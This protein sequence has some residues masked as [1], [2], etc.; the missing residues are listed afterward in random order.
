[1]TQPDVWLPV[2]LANT[3]KTSGRE[4]Y[5][6][7]V[8]YLSLRDFSWLTV[9]GRLKTD[10][11]LKQA[12]AELDNIARLSDDNATVTAHSER[13][14]KVTVAPAT[15]LNLPEARDQIIP[16]GIAATLILTLVLAVVCVNISNML[17]ARA[18]AR[19]KEIGV[20]LA[21]GASRRRIIQQLI[22][23]S[24]LLAIIGAIC[25][26]V[27]ASFFSSV[28]LSILPIEHVY[29][30]TTINWVVFAYCLLAATLA[31][32]LFGVAP[33]I[34]ATR[35][36][37][38][39]IINAQVARVPT[40]RLR[41]SLV[42]AQVALSMVLLT[43]A[44]LLLRGMQRAQSTQLNWQP[45][46][47][48]A[49]SFDLASAGYDNTREAVFFDQLTAQLKGRP[50]IESVGITRSVPFASSNQTI[51]RLDE[52]QEIEARYN[53]VTA[54][55]FKTLRIPI[56]QGRQFTNEEAKAKLPYAVISQA[57]ARRL[58]PAINPIGQHFNSIYEV[59]G[60]TSD[61]SSTTVGK[62]DGPTFYLPAFAGEQVG[63]SLLV[64][65]TQG[66]PEFTQNLK[67][68]VRSLDGNVAVH[69]NSLEEY[70]QRK[71]QPSR[72]A[73]IL[74]SS[75][76][77]LAT[78]MAGLG[79]Y[80]L[81]AFLVSQRIREIGIRMALGAQT[82][83]ILSLVLKQGMKLV[84]IGTGLGLAT[85]LIVSRLLAGLIFGVSNTDA[86]T[87][88]TVP[89]ILGVTAFAACF[90]PARRAARVNPVEALRYE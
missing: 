2:S 42:V 49:V 65:T 37:V 47:V 33:A 48:Y 71:L 85:S 70:L 3:L 34:Q 87:F 81:V 21:L 57:M 24:L 62:L 80:G 90:L 28:S 56:M 5:D 11:S 52:K 38:V 6:T 14:T 84:V 27:L 39:L 41:S 9:I 79:L 82:S 66:R 69:V 78:A 10:A 18:I 63:H 43:C 26:L 54:D 64:R 60:V 22:I 13:H 83:N 44:G 86:L 88:T 25:G 74:S 40:S 51:V 1:V 53:A 8:D 15:L 23:E 55:Y 61:L 77:L 73:A 32:L 58:W 45:E 19:Q 76:S 59:I 72:F 4:S 17:L 36:D 89:V 75:L 35:V 67:H 50:D 20:R 16:V 31:T 29:I 68:L 46:G 7:D 12:Q 30:N